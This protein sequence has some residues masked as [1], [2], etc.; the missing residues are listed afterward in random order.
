MVVSKEEGSFCSPSPAAS[1]PSGSLLTGSRGCS[2]GY[3]PLRS[4]VPAVLKR[5]TMFHTCT[6]WRPCVAF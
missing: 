4:S 3:A 2:K 1:L 5:D 6:W